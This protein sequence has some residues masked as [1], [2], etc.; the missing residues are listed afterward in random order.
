M[1]GSQVLGH[2]GAP[3]PRRAGPGLGTAGP[4]ARLPDPGVH[5]DEGLATLAFTSPLLALFHSPSPM[6]R[7]FLSPHKADGGLGVRRERRVRARPGGE[8]RNVD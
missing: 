8:C 2:Q 4:V 6:W 5:P 3:C 1:L 7:S